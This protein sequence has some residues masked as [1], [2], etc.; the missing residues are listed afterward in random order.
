MPVSTTLLLAIL[1]WLFAKHW[2]CDFILQTKTQLAEKGAYGRPGGL[3]HGLIHIA[4][5][6]PVFL[7]A[8]TTIPV[9]AAMLLGEFLVHYHVDWAKEQVLRRAGWGYQDGRYWSLFGF[10]QFLHGL[11]Y[12]VIGGVLLQPW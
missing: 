2:L 9:V 11:T 8:P 5:T 12:L 4:G 7:L 1:A 10:D 6:A 3:L